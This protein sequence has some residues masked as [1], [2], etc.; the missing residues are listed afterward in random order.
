MALNGDSN[1]CKEIKTSSI[2]FYI[3]KYKKNIIICYFSFS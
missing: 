2:I 1:P 3:G